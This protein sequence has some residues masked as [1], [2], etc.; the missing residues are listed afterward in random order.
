MQRNR[1]YNGIVSEIKLFDNMDHA[2]ISG[3]ELSSVILSQRK[4]VKKLKNNAQ[5][6]Q[7]E[8]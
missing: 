6:V 1:F 5:K 4:C 2:R 7:K 3:I 8:A